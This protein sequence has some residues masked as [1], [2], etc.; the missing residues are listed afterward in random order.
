MTETIKKLS[1]MYDCVEE[2][3][4]RGIICWEEKEERQK[5]IMETWRQLQP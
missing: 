5:E 1:E 3:Y 4:Q 2:E